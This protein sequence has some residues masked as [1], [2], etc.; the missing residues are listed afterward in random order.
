M[1]GSAL[2]KRT[3]TIACL[4]C[5]YSCGQAY[6]GKTADAGEKPA[7]DTAARTFVFECPDDYSFIVRTQSDNAWLFL[8]GK[9]I[10]LPRASS[11]S[12]IKYA[13]D[14]ITF[15]N[16]GNEALLE[17]GDSRHTGCRNNPAKAVWEH[18]KLNGVDF[19][20]TGNEPG[21]YMEISNKRDILFVTDYGQTAYRFKSATIKSEPHAR[22][23]VYNARNRDDS[24][25]IVVTAEPC[26]DTMSGEA[27]SSAVS[28]LINDKRLS[29]CGKPLH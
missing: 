20:A 29:G 28:V 3:T 19:R 2:I 7:V 27:F 24:I 10:D 12:G 5:L 26:R 25:E 4:A 6:T 11:A 23:A 13:G 8:P 18:A 22:S 9:T 14:N 21:W 17:T 1:T 15:W 16:K